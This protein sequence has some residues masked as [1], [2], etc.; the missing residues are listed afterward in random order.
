MFKWMHLTC[1]Q[2]MNKFIIQFN[3][4]NF[5]KYVDKSCTCW[6]FSAWACQ[7]YFIY[8]LSVVLVIF[9]LVPQRTGKKHQEWEHDQGS[10]VSL[11]CIGWFC[12]WQDYGTTRDTFQKTW[13]KIGTRP[14]KKPLNLGDDPGYGAE[15]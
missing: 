3:L 10:Y 6:L 8:I 14:G 7:W 4:R 11:V 9:P 5:T 2:C 15:I 12:R 13:R 1:I